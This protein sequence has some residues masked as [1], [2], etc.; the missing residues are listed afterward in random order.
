MERRHTMTSARA[1]TTTA[2][3]ADTKAKTVAYNDVDMV[4]DR[5]HSSASDE[6][7]G[8]STTDFQDNSED[9]SGGDAPTSRSATPAPGR[10]N[11][12]LDVDREQRE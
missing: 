2:S 3:T 11:V 5:R 7:S 1:T 4:T 9:A 12:E 8:A 10:L 6:N